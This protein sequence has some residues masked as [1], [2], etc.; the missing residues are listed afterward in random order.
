MNEQQIQDDLK[1]NIPAPSDFTPAAPVV[2]EA[3]DGP[4]NL[5]LDEL[6]Q[7]KLQD[8]FG[9]KYRSTDE[10]AKQQAQYVYQA[11]AE[12]VD[13]PEYGFILDK[14]RELENII[15]TANSEKRLYKLYQWLKLDNVRRRTEAEMSALRG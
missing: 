7:Y 14:I 3:V 15:G 2:G 6:T 1:Q 8:F 13:T 4:V 12:R 10:I 11:V 9:V 5:K